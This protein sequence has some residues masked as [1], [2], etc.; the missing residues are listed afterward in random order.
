MVDVGINIALLLPPEYNIFKQSS[1]SVTLHFIS[2]RSSLERWNNAIWERME[3][4]L[5]FGLLGLGLLL[6]KT[7]IDSTRDKESR[8]EARGEE[9]TENGEIY[10]T[11]ARDCCCFC[12][13]KDDR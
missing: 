6:H 12:G 9:G 7:G 4:Y 11:G 8:N 3:R 1:Q 10:G 13:E 5:L 2:T